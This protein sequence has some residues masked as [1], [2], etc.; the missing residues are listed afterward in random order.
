MRLAIY[1]RSLAET[2]FYLA[3]H[4]GPEARRDFEFKSSGSAFQ[5]QIGVRHGECPGRATLLKGLIA[6]QPSS[7]S[8]SSSVTLQ[9]CLPS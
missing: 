7:P 5:Y 3:T 1:S 8:L 9:K 4:S 6:N 2:N